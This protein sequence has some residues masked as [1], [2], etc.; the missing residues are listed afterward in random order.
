[1]LVQLLVC[2][3]VLIKY[4][5]RSISMKINIQ[6]LAVCMFVMGVTGTFVFYTN[7]DLFIFNGNWW[8]FWW[9]VVIFICALIRIT[10]K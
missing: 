9:G 3:H 8:V 7:R 2:L 5:L 1:V 4:V 10:H 6:L